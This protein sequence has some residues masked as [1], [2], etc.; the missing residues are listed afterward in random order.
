MRTDR[1]LRAWLPGLALLCI[2]LPATASEQ[3]DG[4]GKVQHRAEKI[5]EAGKSAAKDFG[6]DASEVGR[7]AVE[8]AKQASAAAAEEVRRATREFWRDVVEEKERL[9]AKLRNENRELRTRKAK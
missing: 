6:H 7:E 8:K 5:V 4:S 9:R 2:A 3:K 1:L